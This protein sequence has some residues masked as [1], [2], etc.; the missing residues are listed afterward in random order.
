VKLGNDFRETK[1]PTGSQYD[2]GKDSDSPLGQPYESLELDNVIH[3]VTG[4]TLAQV[5][6]A[7][8]GLLSKDM[9]KAQR[10]AMFCGR[11]PVATWSH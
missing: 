8:A 7:N 3:F 4:E 9:R 6:Q 10:A 5:S 1:F 11:F 2:Y